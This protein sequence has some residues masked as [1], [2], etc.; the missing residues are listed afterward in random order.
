MGD[1]RKLSRYLQ[2]CTFENTGFFSLGNQNANIYYTDLLASYTKQINK[3]LKLGVVGGYTATKFQ[4][5]YV[6]NETKNGLSVRN[7]FDINASI[8]PS[9]RNEKYNYRNN[10]LR[11]ALFGTLNI[12]F[13]EYWFIEGTLRRE[14]IS[15]MHPDNNVLYYPSVNSS[16]ILSD[17]F[18]LPKLFNY[19]KLR[20]SW[21]IVGSYPDIYKSALFYTQ[22]TLGVQTSNGA[23]VLYTSLPTSSF[24]NEKIKPETK[25]EVEFGLETRLLNG[26]LGFDIT[27]Y[28]G[29]VKDQIIEYTL[30]N[31]TGASSILANVGSLR[32]SGWEFAINATPIQNNIFKWSTV[33]NFSMSKS[34]KCDAQNCRWIY[35]YFYI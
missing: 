28:N 22:E 3:D 33:L 20:G 23:A 10:M 17:L 31:S 1:R 24:G 6:Q 19:A 32:N 18:Q 2:K 9:V 35:Q 30:P 11:D 34:R 21:G 14:R 5:T 25:N 16:L 15:T 12:N 4:D 26:R 8:S 27:Y 29:L 13:K 7:W